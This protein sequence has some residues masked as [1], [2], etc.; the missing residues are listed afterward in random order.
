MKILILGR[1]GQVGTA[2]TS[3]L[4][5]LGEIAAY[6]R[7]GADFTSPDDVE[8]LVRRERADIIV[9]AAA[10]TA[11]DKAES[12][13]EVA[14]LVNAVSP[15]RLAEIAVETGARLFHISTD[16]VFDGEQAESYREDDATS[17]INVYGQTKLE[18]EAAIA[19]TGADFVTLRTSWVHS[20]SHANF[21]ARILELAAQREEMQVIDDQSGCPTSA[22]LLAS[23]IGR[24]IGL[25]AAGRPLPAGLYHLT[26]SG[27]TSR[28][29]YAAFIVEEARRLGATLAVKRIVPVSSSA[30]PTPAPRPRNAHLSNHRLCS[31]LGIDLPDWRED[32][33]PTIATLVGA[34]S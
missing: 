15:G 33:R 18:G 32:V 16:Y 8:R 23:T 10:Y 9:N 24:I 34:A 28:Y 4:A 2:L 12:E 7:A 1:D 29:D 6:G 14:R 20:A 11:V 19:A 27:E 25:G 3:I 30:F 21:A 22:R 13:P 26:T 31:A 17:P 5:P